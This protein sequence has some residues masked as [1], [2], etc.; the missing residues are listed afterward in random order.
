MCKH[1]AHKLKP[2]SARKKIVELKNYISNHIHTIR[3]LTH[4]LGTI[5]STNAHV[6]A[7]RLKG[8]GRS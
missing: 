3:I 2:G 4:E 1:E 5:G 8:Q 6:G 7:A